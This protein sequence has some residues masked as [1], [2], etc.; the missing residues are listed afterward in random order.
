MIPFF[1][2]FQNARTDVPRGRVG[3]AAALFDELHRVVR[4]VAL[5][6]ED[7]GA[8]RGSAVTPVVAVSVDLAA[9]A[10][11]FERGLRALNQFRDRDQEEGTVNIFQPE[12]FDRRFVR[13]GFGRLR[14]THVDDEPHAEVAQ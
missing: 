6:D 14:K 3:D 8:H 11:R 4:I 13:V 7:A 10:D 12:H 9:V 2:K 1:C 5:R